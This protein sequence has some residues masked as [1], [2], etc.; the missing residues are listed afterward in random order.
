M[1]MN[2]HG[3]TKKKS[4]RK[5]VVGILIVLVVLANV[6]SFVLPKRIVHTVSAPLYGVSAAVSTPFKNIAAY[7]T[8]RNELEEEK[9]ALNERIKELEVSLLQQQVL[10]KMEDDRQVEQNL[11]PEGVTLFVMTRPPYSPYDTFVVRNLNNTLT[12]GDMVY[13]RGVL[14]GTISEVFAHTSIVRLLS[15]PDTQTIVRVGSLDAEATGYGGG[16]YV[17]SLPKD[18]AVAVGDVITVPAYGNQL[19]GVVASIENQE[20]SSFQKVYASVPTS[21]ADITFVTVVE[22]SSVL[23]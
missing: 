20:G 8:S 10:Q 14:I 6:F 2:Y 1:K 7:F 5:K 3:S 13:A 18:V 23:E 21:L 15:S 4:P 9:R 22:G 19:L 17:I 12:V 11:S 16:R